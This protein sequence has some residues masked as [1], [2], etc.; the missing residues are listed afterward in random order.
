MIIEYINFWP[1]FEN[2]PNIF[3]DFLSR[4]GDVLRKLEIKGISKIQ[5]QSVFP[6]KV[7]KNP[8]QRAISKIGLPPHYELSNADPTCLKIWFTGEN[9]RP[10]LEKNLDAYLSFDLD[11]FGGRNF[12]FPLVYLSLNPYTNN[13]QS[14]LGKEYQTRT[15]LN[16]RHLQTSKIR[17]SI[18]I[19]A[20]KHPIRSAVVQEFAK[21]FQVDVFGGM[22]AAPVSEKYSIARKYEY[23]FC[24]E[25]DLYPGYVTEK[26]VEAYVCETVPLYWGLNDGN[27]YLNNKSFLNLRDFKDIA[28][29]AHHVKEISPKKYFEI[30]QEPLLLSEPPVQIQLSRLFESILKRREFN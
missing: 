28:A 9:I 1:G 7:K 16:Q 11:P 29:W 15:L 13:F 3:D 22:S 21:Y 17:N 5:F 10:P 23:M 6:P 18:C 2:E 20:G 27:P 26:L 12:Y 24:L 4:S 14:R 25:N 8:V 30:Y 19:I